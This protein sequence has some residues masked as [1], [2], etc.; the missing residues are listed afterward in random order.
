MSGAEPAAVLGLIS[1]VIAIV[2]A[3]QRI[4]QATHDASG[5]PEA[6][7]STSQNIPLVLS[8]LQDVRRV[9]EQADEEYKQT[10]DPV[11]KKEIEEE[12]RAV[13]VAVERCK[14]NAEALQEIFEKVIPGD[15]ASRRERYFKAARTVVPGKKTQVEDL[16]SEILTKLQALHVRY[17]FKQAAET[18]E[19]KSAQ[20]DEAI[21]KLSELESLIRGASNAVESVPDWLTAPDPYTDYINALKL[22]EDHTGSWLLNNEHYQRWKTGDTSSM[23]LVGIPGC[24]KTVMSATIVQD[25]QNHCATDG[26]SVVYFYFNFKSASKQNLSVMIKSLIIQ[27]LRLGHALPSAMEKLMMSGTTTSQPSIYVL[28]DYLQQMTQT[29]KG[30]YIILDAL[31]ECRDRSEL[32]STVTQMIGWEKAHILFTSREDADIKDALERSVERDAT[33][34]FRSENVD[35]DIRFYL[36]RKLLRDPGFRRWRTKP[37]VLRD[38]ETKLTDKSRGM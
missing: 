13:Q 20:L 27:L 21:K 19:Q 17:F 18:R 22:R 3:S 1:S 4:Y 29:A 38:I 33:I 15:K 10:Q 26:S 6:F 31:D 5:L 9:Q 23:W 2:E 36:R 24:G 11:K 16:M 14:S 7:R 25:I 37:A 34:P 28:L 32:L 12:A 30:C 8:T 35:E